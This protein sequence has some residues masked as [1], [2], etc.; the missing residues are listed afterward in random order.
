M[1]KS[2][3][4]V[5]ALIRYMWTMLQTLC[6]IVTTIYPRSFI[7]IRVYYGGARPGNLGGPLVKVKRLSKFFPESHSQYNL[8]YALSNTPYLSNTALN[9]LQSKNIPLVLNQNGVFYP[10]WY[11]GNCELMNAKMK[12]L[13]HRADYVFWQ[14]NFCRRAA[15]YFLGHR[16]GPGEILFNAIDTEHFL[17]V[18][19]KPDRPFTFLL[20]GIIPLHLQYRVMSAITGLRVAHDSGLKAQ[21]IIA[22]KVHPSVILHANQIIK[23]LDLSNYVSFLGAYNQ[24]EAP[25][26]YRLA[27]AYIMTKYMDPCPNAVLEA[28]SCGLPVLYSNSGGV[29]EL[30]GPDAGIPLYV[31]EDWSTPE[32]L[33]TSDLIGGA[34]IDISKKVDEMSVI[35]RTRA[36]DCFNI[37]TWIARH[38]EI[39]ENLIKLRA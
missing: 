7:G 25:S 38:R 12:G 8:I 35:A 29:P 28:M 26:I 21:L 32:I 9:I 36:Q 17:P 27:D 11:G 2:H 14:S 37:K 33:P 16:D 24:E 30:V 18:E 22:G 3:S 23:S 5:K 6:V 31:S 19:K 20:T 10:G 39:F 13:Y 1:I 15:N 34:M 4:V